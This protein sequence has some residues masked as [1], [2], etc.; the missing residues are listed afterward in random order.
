MGVVALVLAG[1]GQGGGESGTTGGTTGGTKPV[2]GNA[3]ALELAFVTNN[4]SD[5]WTIAEKG[6]EK[7]KGEVRGISVDFKLP[8]NGTAAEQTQIIDDLLS[9]GVQGIAI[10]PKDPANQV[11]LIND[12]AKKV[13][14]ITQD[15]D[16]P[17]SNRA[18]YI[19]TD[20]VAAGVEAGKQ[21]LKALPN[22]GKIMA[23]VGSK[24]AQNAKDR[25][26][27]VVQALKGSKVQLL[28]VRTDETDH[29]KAVANVSDALVKFPD[30]ALC[31][32]LWSYNGPAIL[33]AVKQAKKEGLVKI[34]CFDEEDDTLSGIK[35]GFISATIVQ[36]PFVFG[37]KAIQVMA[38]YLRGD[39]S[40]IP[41]D[42]KILV[43]TKVIDKSNVD[44]FRTNLN[45]LRGRA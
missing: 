13:L 3:K 38:A 9:K 42:K 40:V 25:L 19:G 1:C 31:V 17:T 45:K 8:A 32:G 43:P 7:A 6:V 27:G 37:E 15:S 24:D 4:A 12:T 18:C 26:D 2:A 21:I 39:K 41:A 36:Q 34:V 14:V 22:G 23:F 29:T 30:L 10:S 16:A 5:Y 28:D 35:D 11:Q 20:N 33:N 44:T